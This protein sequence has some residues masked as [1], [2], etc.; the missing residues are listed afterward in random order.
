MMKTFSTVLLSLSLCACAPMHFVN[1]PVIGDTVKREHWHHLTG[2][3]LI[4]LSQPFNMDYYC[5][6][7]EWE[8]ISVLLTTPNVLASASIL[9]NPWSIHYECRDAI[10]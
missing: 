8:K 9:Y 3:G 7:K 5:D 6:N 10:E 4:E 1:G 2:A